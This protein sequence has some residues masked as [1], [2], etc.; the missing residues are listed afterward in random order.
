MF[1]I[2]ELDQNKGIG[3]RNV[4]T[5]KAN[6]RLSGFKSRLIQNSGKIYSFLSY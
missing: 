5:L 4:M 1:K 6:F 2:I 3:T